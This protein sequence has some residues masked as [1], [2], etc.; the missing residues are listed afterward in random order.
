MKVRIAFT[1]RGIETF[2]KELQKRLKLN[3]RI[4]F[5]LRGIETYLQETLD[6]R[7]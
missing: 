3:V 6:S 7:P 4:A 1:L 2:H 5:T